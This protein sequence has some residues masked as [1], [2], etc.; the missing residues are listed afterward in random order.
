M[1]S[2]LAQVTCHT[3]QVLLAGGQVFFL[4]DLPFLPHLTI[5]SAQNELNNLDRPEN[6]N[7]KKKKKKKKI[8]GRVLGFLVGHP[9]VPMFVLFLSFL[10]DNL[11]KYQ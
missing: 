4:G 7:Q 5:D 10:E 11:N 2:S 8:S 9:C 3:S 1:G 6:P